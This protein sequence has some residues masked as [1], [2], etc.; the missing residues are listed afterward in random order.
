M[1]IEKERREEEKS[2]TM[3]WVRHVRARIARMDYFKE[4]GEGIF[5]REDEYLYVTS[6]NKQNSPLPTRI[7]QPILLLL[8]L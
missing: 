8:I 4:V 1:G 5:A 3:R 2:C 6:E 7:S